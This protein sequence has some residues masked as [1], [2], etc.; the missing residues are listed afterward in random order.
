MELKRIEKTSPNGKISLYL[1]A[2][3]FSQ[4]VPVDGVIYLD[5]DYMLSRCKVLVEFVGLAHILSGT[6]LDSYKTTI[7]TTTK[8]LWPRSEI[9]ELTGFQIKLVRDLG[10]NAVPFTLDIPQ[11][12]PSSIILYSP[13]YHELNG[14]CY[15]I[16]IHCEDKLHFNDEESAICMEVGIIN[17]KL[18]QDRLPCDSLCKSMSSF[19][20]HGEIKMK[21]C[22]DKELFNNGDEILVNVILNNNTKTMVKRIKAWIQQDVEIPLARHLKKRCAIIDQI[23]V[24]NPRLG[25]RMVFALKL[26]HGKLEVGKELA[27]NAPLE[28]GTIALGSSTSDDCRDLRRIDVAYCVKVKI[29]IGGLIGDTLTAKLPFI[30]GKIKVSD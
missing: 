7:F 3:Y 25:A 11:N 9:T 28:N 4:N 15:L 26:A 8:Q 30:V 27:V 29:Y 2:R 22:L 23:E 24:K 19:F 6:G 12:L 1:S 13:F 14:I 16:K 20:N 17:V 10:A 18:E 21:V 5:E